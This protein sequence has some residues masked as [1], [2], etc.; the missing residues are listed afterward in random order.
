MK[1]HSGEG[2]ITYDSGDVYEGA[3]RNAEPDGVGKMTYKDGHICEG[4]WEYGAL[5][6]KDN[7]TMRRSLMEEAN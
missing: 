6:L 7:W 1:N 4:I 2:T 5:I 3:F